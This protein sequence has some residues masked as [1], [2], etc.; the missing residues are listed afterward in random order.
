V[1]TNIKE[2]KSMRDPK[3]IEKAIN[4]LR[5]VWYA[6]SDLRLGQLILAV[7]NEDKLFYMEDGAL[8]KAIEEFYLA[9]K[10]K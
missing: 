2:N 7:V 5:T 6:N 3:R 9:N 8:M 4:T 10:E 1:P